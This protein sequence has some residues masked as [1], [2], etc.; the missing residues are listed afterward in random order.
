MPD[1]SP[2]LV[3]NLTFPIEQG[4]T[5]ERP[6]VDLSISVDGGMSF[7]NSDGMLLNPKGKY[8]NQFVYWNLG[9]CNEFTPQFRLWG[10][11]RFVAGNGTMGVYQ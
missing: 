2:F 3:N 7:G 6:R 5:D 4:T 9:Y 1:T 10:K 8:M 11:G